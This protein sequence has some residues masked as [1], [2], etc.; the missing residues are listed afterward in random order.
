M[1]WAYASFYL[2][3]SIP[4]CSKWP[5]GYP[6]K[7]NAAARCVS[8]KTHLAIDADVSYTVVRVDPVV[9]EGAGIGPAQTAISTPETHISTVA[10]SVHRLASPHANGHAAKPGSTVAALHTT[11]LLPWNM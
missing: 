8:N 9:T 4:V 6:P 2:A 1:V 5:E 3:S 10:K 7:K 11:A